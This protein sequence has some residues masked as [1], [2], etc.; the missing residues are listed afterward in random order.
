MGFTISHF[1]FLHDNYDAICD[2]I[3]DFVTSFFAGRTEYFEDAFANTT[4]KPGAFALAF[5][6]GLFSYAGW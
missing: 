3:T 5:Y 6:S 1:D 2:A 4:Q